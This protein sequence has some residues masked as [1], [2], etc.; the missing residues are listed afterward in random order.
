MSSQLH[1]N[2]YAQLYVG[3]MNAQSYSTCVN[4]LG[5]TVDGVEISEIHYHEDIYTDRLGGHVPEDIQNFGSEARIT[6]DL[7]K[8]DNAVLRSIITR[9]YQGTVGTT[10]NEPSM[11]GDLMVACSKMFSLYVKRQYGPDC[12]NPATGSSSNASVEGGWTFP[13]CMVVDER[14]WKVGTKVTRHRLV[15]R[16][17]PG[18]TGVLYVEG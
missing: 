6:L 11:A 4:E 7:I 14:S 1:V 17:I 18:S 15:I 8:Y 10:P 16:A 3:P 12:Q 13:R 2:G 9:N 5:W